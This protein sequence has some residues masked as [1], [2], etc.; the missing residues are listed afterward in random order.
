MKKFL[1]ILLTICFFHLSAGYFTAPAHCSGCKKS[2]TLLPIRYGIS[3]IPASEAGFFFAGGCIDAGALWACSS[4]E[5]RHYPPKNIILAIAEVKG[6]PDTPVQLP[7]NADYI[8]ANRIIVTGKSV[9][10]TGISFI[11]PQKDSLEIFFDARELSQLKDFLNNSTASEIILCRGS[12]WI[13]VNRKDLHIRERSLKISPFSERCHFWAF[14]GLKKY[15]CC[16][17]CGS[18]NTLKIAVFE[19]KNDF[20]EAVK[21]DLAIYGGEKSDGSLW[22]CKECRHREKLPIPPALQM[23]IADHE[24]ESADVIPAGT[25]TV[26][27]NE[28]YYQLG[29]KLIFEQPEYAQAQVNDRLPEW[30]PGQQDQ[31][32]G[33]LTVRYG[34]QDAANLLE[35]S[36]KHLGKPA[37]LMVCGIPFA[38]AIIMMPIDSRALQLHGTKHIGLAGLAK[39][40]R[41]FNQR[42]IRDRQISR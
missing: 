22:G 16:P 42:I 38:P 3:G 17:A 7:A 41:L 28:R 10:F 35:F 39:I 8:A 26:K 1:T 37:I 9:E 12:R 29:D 24:Y 33:Y 5:E 27:I 32:T 15:F 6:R 40:A 34:R 19:N 21:A 30:I 31:T 2:G 23:Y 14:T 18:R 13:A 4:C 20:V 25:E 36:G 11:I